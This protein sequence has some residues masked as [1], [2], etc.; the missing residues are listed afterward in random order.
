[1]KAIMLRFV[2]NFKVFSTWIWSTNPKMAQE[3][4]NSFWSARR[5]IICQF[6]RKSRSVVLNYC[7]K[8]SFRTTF[9]RHLAWN[10]IHLLE[11]KNMCRYVHEHFIRCVFRGRIHRRIAAIRILLEAIQPKGWTGSGLW[12]DTRTMRTVAARELHRQN[13]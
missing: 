3:R 6:V 12:P 4:V 13:M 11:M 2:L 8:F 10:M 7:F 9:I 1:M 5:L